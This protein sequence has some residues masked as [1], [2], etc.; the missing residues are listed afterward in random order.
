MV[1]PV[2][3]LAWP[4]LPKAGLS[5]LEA[6]GMHVQPLTKVRD[7]S[8][9][10]TNEGMCHITVLALPAPLAFSLATADVGHVT[11]ILVHVAQQLLLWDDGC[12]CACVLIIS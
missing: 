7:G 11:V 1:F 5:A 9:S 6:C 2:S 12:I 3:L 8:W 10:H 4:V